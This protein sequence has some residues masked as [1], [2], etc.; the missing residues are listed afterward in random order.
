MQFTHQQN[1]TAMLRRILTAVVTLP[2]MVVSLIAL[3][4]AAFANMPAPDPGGA[5]PPDSG[6]GAPSPTTVITVSHSSPLWVF[7][8]VAAV[9]AAVTLAVVLAADR[10]RRSSRLRTAEA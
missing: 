1:G 4:P 7:V 8:L 9:S 10:F 3:G 2:A 5:L 6:A